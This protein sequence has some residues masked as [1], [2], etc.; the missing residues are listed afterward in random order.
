MASMSR[1]RHASASREKQGLSSSPGPGQ[2]P[3]YFEYALVLSLLSVSGVH[4]LSEYIKEQ[5]RHPPTWTALI[6]PNQEHNWLVL[7]EQSTLV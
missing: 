7:S 6:A 3:E 5:L 4:V 2:E 1:M